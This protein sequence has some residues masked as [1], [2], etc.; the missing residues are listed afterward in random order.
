MI[1]VIITCRYHNSAHGYNELVTY[2]ENVISGV[3]SIRPPLPTLIALGRLDGR[4]A[5]S[6]A[7]DIWLARARIDGTATIAGI[8]GLP[9]FADD[10]MNWICGRAA[11]PRHSEGLNDPM[12]VAAVMHF[13]LVA[14]Q[15][16]ADE[17][18]KASL[19]ILRTLLD[20]RSEAELW[21]PGDLV[22]FSGA[23]RAAQGAIVAPYPAPTLHAVA[24]RLLEV[25]AALEVE[26]APGRTV[27]TV[28]GRQMVIEPQSF[29]T[30]WLVACQLPRAL[31][32]A[33]LA[34]HIL[35]SMV[36]LPRFLPRSA[37]ELANALEGSIGLASRQGLAELDRLERR[38]ESLPSVLPVTKRSRLPEL[39]RLELAYP[40]LRVPAV[41]R[42]LGVSPQAAAKLALRARELRVGA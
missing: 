31:V 18:A 6:P 25:H 14:Q 37:D 32:A 40:G 15:M 29:A 41:S 21:G 36:H 24:E 5:N 7:R 33:G 13:V 23:F 38:L 16:P 2:V 17:I 26:P 3:V 27:T 19:R 39:L 10:I 42:L 8:A 20:D 9:V 35:P 1:S 30:I 28:D 12:S 11:P 4:L 22:R 34:T